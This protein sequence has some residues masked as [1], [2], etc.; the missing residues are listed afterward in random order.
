[1][2]FYHKDTILA[3]PSDIEEDKISSGGQ[4]ELRSDSPDAQ[5]PS[6]AQAQD[7]MGWA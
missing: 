1:M 7:S 3:I 6:L 5:S 2:K 4:K